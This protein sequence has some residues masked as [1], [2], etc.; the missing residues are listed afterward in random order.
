MALVRAYKTVKRAV[1]ATLFAKKIS[2]SDID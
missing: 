1:C 2:V